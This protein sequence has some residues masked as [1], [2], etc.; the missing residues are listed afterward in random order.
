MTATT[1]NTTTTPSSTQQ[2][3]DKDHRYQPITVLYTLKC[4]ICHKKET[5]RRLPDE[6]QE[7]SQK[8]GYVSFFCTNCISIVNFLI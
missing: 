5:L 7:H 3:L 6:Y 1:T 4:S 8:K 2:D